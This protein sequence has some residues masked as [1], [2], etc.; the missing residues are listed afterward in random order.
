MAEQVNRGGGKGEGELD[1]NFTV[2]TNNII[3]RGEMKQ[4]VL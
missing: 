4:I 2:A 1:F 3:N